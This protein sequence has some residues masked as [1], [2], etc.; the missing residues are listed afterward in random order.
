MD[1]DIHPISIR[2]Q[3][4]VTRWEGVSQ[5]ATVCPWGSGSPFDRATRSCPPD[6]GQTNR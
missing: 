1:S 2:A 4:E 3:K 5:E 6:R